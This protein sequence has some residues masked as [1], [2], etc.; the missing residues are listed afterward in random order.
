[1]VDTPRTLAEVKALLADNT[2]GDISP[3]DLRDLVESIADPVLEGGLDR[4]GVSVVRATTSQ[5]IANG[6]ALFTPVSFDGYEQVNFDPG[7]ASD[8]PDPDAM[9]SVSSPTLVDLKRAGWWFLSAGVIWAA[10]ATGRREAAISANTF[11]HDAWM[12]LGP[13]APTG[14]TEQSGGG[15]IYVPAVSVAAEEIQLRVN[16]TSG[17]PLDIEFAFL[18]GVWFR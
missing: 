5:S 16:Q 1:M 13:A 8:T 3:Q 7:P 15:A 18:T 12:D 14:A 2:T 11:G 4:V 6:A 9:W 17:G 10:N